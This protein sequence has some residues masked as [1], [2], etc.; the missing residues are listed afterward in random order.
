MQ[1]IW[2]TIS[3]RGYGLK[4]VVIGSHLLWFK[5]GYNRW[6]RWKVPP[7]VGV[8]VRQKHRVLLVGPSQAV[9][10]AA[11]SLSMLRSPDV[12]HG[13][14]IQ[15]STQGSVRKRGKKTWTR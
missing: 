3:G 2:R 8:L 15:L 12:Y 6:K 10:E 13:K 11:Q 1:R 14:G 7:Q 5:L 4:R 9:G